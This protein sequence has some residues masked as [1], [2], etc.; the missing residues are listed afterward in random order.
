MSKHTTTPPICAARQSN[1]EL[2]RCVSMFMVLMMHTSFITFG[3]PTVEGTKNEPLFCGLQTL[4]YSVAIVAVNVFVMISGWFSIKPKTKGITSFLFQV[5]FLKLLSFGF[6]VLAGYLAL[7]KTS[8]ADLLMLKP[9]TG[10]F[11]KAYI[12]LYILA[13][14]LNAF[15]AN[16]NR[17]VYKRVLFFYFV[18]I[19]LL[20]WF[21]DITGYMMGGYSISMFVG[22]YL[23]ARYVKVYSPS[24]SMFSKQK[25]FIIYLLATMVTFC[26][27]YIPVCLG[28]PHCDTFVQ[29]FTRYSSP[30]VVLGALFFLLMFSKLNIGAKT[31]INTIAK[32]CFAVYL[33]HFMWGILPKVVINL[34]DNNSI[35]M[36]YIKLV[37]LLLV[38]FFSCILIDRVRIEI[39]N[40]ISSKLFCIN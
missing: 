31:G 28:L 10:W 17:H 16:T 13:P 25:D 5:A 33:L 14:V 21:K 3:F 9:Y 27:I 6:F 40:K 32:S 4:Q 11:I 39:W 8:L 20:G 36:F 18:F 12:L 15:V 1:I 24:W 2:L 34:Y 26:G 19:F 30:F 7:D 22:L 35:T 29:A 38:I 23:L 37:G